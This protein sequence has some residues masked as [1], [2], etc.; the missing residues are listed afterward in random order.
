MVHRVAGCAYTQQDATSDRD[1]I[2][3]DCQQI[4][5]KRVAL[6]EVSSSKSGL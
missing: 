3:A 5:V 4:T 2:L 1:T 6:G